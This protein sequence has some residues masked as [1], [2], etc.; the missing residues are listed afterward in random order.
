MQCTC[1]NIKNTLDFQ[2]VSPLFTTDFLFHRFFTPSQTAQTS[3]PP[4]SPP[5]AARPPSTNERF[6]TK[7]LTFLRRPCRVV[8]FEGLSFRGTS[9]ETGTAG[10]AGGRSGRW[11]SLGRFGRPV[12]F[13]KRKSYCRLVVGVFLVEVFLQGDVRGTE[14]C[15]EFAWSSRVAP[16]TD[17]SDMF[18]RNSLS[19]QIGFS[20]FRKKTTTTIHPWRKI[21][22]PNDWGC[23][24]KPLLATLRSASEVH[25][26]WG[27]RKFL[28]RP[29]GG[30]SL[31][32]D[33]W[34]C[35]GRSRGGL[36]A[37]E[38]QAQ[39]LIVHSWES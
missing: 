21:P 36:D 2:H 38:D 3:H 9:E 23:Q 6:Q 34:L 39:I 4:K 11:S 35:T 32:E 30:G 31:F 25:R 8:Y 13:W 33:D 7:D 10:A 15:L 27:V 26:S 20:F 18:F 16:C 22:L 1:L 5:P 24:R 37:W 19:S 29:L 17:F 14:Q 28:P 12:W